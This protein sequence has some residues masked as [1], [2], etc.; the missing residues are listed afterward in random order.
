VLAG[1]MV[2]TWRRSLDSFRCFEYDGH[3]PGDTVVYEYEYIY[4]LVYGGMRI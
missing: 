4:I 2:K 3:N 1:Q